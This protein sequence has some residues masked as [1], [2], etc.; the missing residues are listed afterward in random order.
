[1]ELFEYKTKLPFPVDEVFALTIDL[2]KAPHWHA[3]FTRIEQITPGQI[4]VGTEWRVSHS[5]GSF[6]LKIIEMTPHERV[7]FK[8]STV[9]G[10][11]PN[12]TIEFAPAQIGTAIHYYLHPDAPRW[13]Q[14]PMRWFAPSFG[15]KDLDRYYQEMELLL[16][17]L[18]RGFS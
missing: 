11:T 9:M 10:M 6:T 5:F 16:A 3:F 7:V 8:G 4:D 1:M 13:L 2:E 18:Q 17:E 14:P 15:R 12:F